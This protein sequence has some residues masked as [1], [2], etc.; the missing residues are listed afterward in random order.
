MTVLMSLSWTG[1]T[2]PLAMW[3]YG[4]IGAPHPIWYLGE[5]RSVWK[6]CTSILV[7]APWDMDVWHGM[8]PGLYLGCTKILYPATRESIR[9]HSRDVTHSCP[10][11]SVKYR[12]VPGPYLGCYQTGWSFLRTS[13]CYA[14]VPGGR[15]NNWYFALF[16]TCQVDEV[17]LNFHP[18]S[19]SSGV[20]LWTTYA[21]WPFLKSINMMDLKMCVKYN[22]VIEQF[23]HCLCALHF[24]I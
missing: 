23:R 7:M 18:P 15:D 5:S 2:W 10:A 6:L 13:P 19:I 24:N 9:G 11:V 21:I 22:G 17:F 14:Q 1:N 8:Y 4:A 20:L 16:C 12:K 3:N